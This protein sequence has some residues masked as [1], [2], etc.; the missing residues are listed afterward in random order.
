MQALSQTGELRT[1]V[2]EV[3]DTPLGLGR[4]TSG[5]VQVSGKCEDQFAA[6]DMEYGTS[7][8]DHV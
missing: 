5:T 8:R 7:S 4:R 6:I 2:K 1:A 3:P